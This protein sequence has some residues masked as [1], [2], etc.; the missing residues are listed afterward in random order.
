MGWRATSNCLPVKEL[1]KSRRVL[2]S[3]TCPY[4]G[5]DSETVYHALV[6]CLSVRDIW[7]NT[8]V[9]FRGVISSN[10]LFWLQ[11]IYS[12]CSKVDFKQVLM[13]CWCIW[14]RQ[15]TYVWQQKLLS[16]TSVS[17]FA[18]TYLHNWKVAR[19]IDLQDSDMHVAQHSFSPS[20]WIAPSEERLKLNV[21][22]ALHMDKNK[23]GY[24]FL[25]RNHLGYVTYAQ[26]GASPGLKQPTVA[27]C[28]GLQE[29]LSWLKESIMSHVDVETDSLL[30]ASFFQH[31]FLP[32]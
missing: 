22:A 31:H 8:G 17:V 20:R 27:E 15:N 3:E 30:V 11:D 32:L 26:S 16:P 6:S 14:N 2:D 28:M 19:G 9:G 21:D 10:F 12:N 24:G 5:G 23:T 13:T 4:C 1:L 29:T 25:V 18:T 7:Q